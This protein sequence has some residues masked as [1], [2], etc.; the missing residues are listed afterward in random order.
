MV[1]RV[2]PSGPRSNPAEFAPTHGAQVT[3]R[4][5]SAASSIWLSSCRPSGDEDKLTSQSVRSVPDLVD[6]EVGRYQ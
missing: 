6:D 3:S 4:D 2:V 1:Q 5:K